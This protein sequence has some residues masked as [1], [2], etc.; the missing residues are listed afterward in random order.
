MQCHGDVRREDTDSSHTLM[1]TLLTNHSTLT[2]PFYFGRVEA[3]V[4]VR[5]SGQ[6]YDFSFT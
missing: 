4:V 6:K 2:Q 3:G 5:L 1:V